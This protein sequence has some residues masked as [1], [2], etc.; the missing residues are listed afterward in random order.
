MVFV[1]EGRMHRK[2]R[3]WRRHHKRHRVRTLEPMPKGMR[4]LSDFGRRMK[5]LVLVE[6]D[7]WPELFAV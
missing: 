6:K 3:L 7:L 2:D 1:S 5:K 4:W